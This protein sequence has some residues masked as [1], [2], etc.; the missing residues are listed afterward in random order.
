MNKYISVILM[1]KLMGLPYIDKPGGLIQVWQKSVPPTGEDKATTKRIPISAIYAAMTNCDLT[2]EK[3]ISYVPE[4]KLKGMFYFEDGGASLNSNKRSP[5]VNFWRSR[6]RLVAWFNTKNI[7]SQQDIMFTSNAQQEMISL[8]PSKPI[9]VDIFK[10]FYVE[11][12]NI[13]AMESSIFPYDYDEKETQFLLPPYAF[14][15]IDLDVYYGIPK[16]CAIPVIPDTITP[17]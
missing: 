10:Q 17:C 4:S 11:P 8:L 7:Q 3:L 2:D 13:L 16:G 15:A 12:T 14:F 6:L 1:T 5:S 9:N